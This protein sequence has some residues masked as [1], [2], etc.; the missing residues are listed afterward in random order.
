MRIF[1]PYIVSDITKRTIFFSWGFSRV[2]DGDENNCY[3]D[4]SVKNTDV[5]QNKFGAV[6]FVMKATIA[7]SFGVKKRSLLVK[8]KVSFTCFGDD[9]SLSMQKWT[10]S[11]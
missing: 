9:C 5:P 1:Q 7:V 3:F 10:T 8:V 11:F 4:F 2:F 6:R